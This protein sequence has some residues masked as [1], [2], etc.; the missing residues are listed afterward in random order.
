MLEG[1]LELAEQEKL[2]SLTNAND[3]RDGLKKK[4]RSEIEGL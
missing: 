3:E 4:M 1:Q 2:N